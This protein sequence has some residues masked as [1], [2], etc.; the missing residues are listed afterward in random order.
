VNRPE[1]VNVSTSL[2]FDTIPI[3]SQYPP[4][5]PRLGTIDVV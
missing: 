4:L 5:R 2:R 1:S 3:I